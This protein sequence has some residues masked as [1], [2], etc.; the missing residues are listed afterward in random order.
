[1]DTNFAG[2]AYVYTTGEIA[3]DPVLLLDE[4]EME[5]HTGI[6]SY[7]RTFELLD[8]SARFDFIQGYQ[9]GHWKGLLNGTP[10]STSR[11]GLS[12]TVLRFSMNLFGGPPLT[13]KEFA[14]YQA[15]VADEGETIA[16]IGL[17]M[18]LPTGHYLED[19]LLNIGTNRF[20]FRPQLGVVRSH[21]PWSVELTGSSWIYTD[22]DD[23]FGGNSLEKD[24][25]YALQTHLVY[26]FRPGLWIS[27]GAAYGIG[28][29]STINGVSKDDRKGNAAWGASIGYPI[30]PQLGVKFGY[31][32]I[33]TQE[34]VGGDTDRFTAGFSVP[35]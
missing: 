27:T 19:R 11:T 24:P 15:S 29:Q 20:T 18:Q 12:D 5:V 14:A 35:W 30:T 17:S 7:I 26:T 16:G 34:I 21:G 6:F 28:G 2:S 1:M 4:V 13:K 9:N 25:L 8:K 32:G 33:R 10:A 31:I 23:F 22:N 3:F